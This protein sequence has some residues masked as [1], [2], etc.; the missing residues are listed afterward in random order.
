MNKEGNA[1][2]IIPL[3]NSSK[4]I[5]GNGSCHFESELIKLPENFTMN[6]D[7]LFSYCKIMMPT[8]LNVKGHLSFY[9][10]KL[11]AIP[12]ELIVE[13]DITIQNCNFSELAKN[14]KTK[15]DFLI[16]DSTISVPPDSV[17]VAESFVYCGTDKNLS[18]KLPKTLKTK[19]LHLDNIS[20]DEL[21]N[22]LVVEE[23]IITEWVKIKN[24]KNITKVYGS[25]I[26]NRSEIG[27][28]S[29]NL[30]IRRNFNLIGSSVEEMPQDLRVGGEFK[31]HNSK[32][33]KIPDT[34]LVGDCCKTY[35]KGIFE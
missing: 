19:H 20:I 33:E 7:L 9:N 29:K 11:L 17:E 27:K 12:D 8:H 21:P 34:L 24:L 25:F 23:D 16:N 6:G 26:L 35:I 14:V 31:I 13:K 15:A 32:I 18:V 2:Y 30:V 5:M 3:D 4:E 22:N 1:I 28:M 10:C